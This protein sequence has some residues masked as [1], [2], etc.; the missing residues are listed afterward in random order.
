MGAAGNTEKTQTGPDAGG[1]WEKAGLWAVASERRGRLNAEEALQAP[2]D[3]LT[4]RMP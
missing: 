4:G 1:C 2:E 3:A